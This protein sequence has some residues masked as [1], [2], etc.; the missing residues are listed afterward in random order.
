MLTKFALTW[1]LVST[2]HVLLSG[3]GEPAKPIIFSNPAPE[4][5]CLAIFANFCKA[6]MFYETQKYLPFF[7]QAAS[8]LPLPLLALFLLPEHFEILHLYI[9]PV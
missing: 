8:A 6:F 2:L 1:S 9:H 5:V 3:R 4:D 7:E